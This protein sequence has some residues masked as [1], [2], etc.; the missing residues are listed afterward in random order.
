MISTVISG[1][2]FKNSFTYIQR[3]FTF[4]L[5][6]IPHIPLFSSNSFLK[7]KYIPDD[8]YLLYFNV[9]NKEM[10][11]LLKTFALILCG[12]ALAAKAVKSLVFISKKLNM[13]ENKHAKILTRDV[14]LKWVKL[15]VY[16]FDDSLQYLFKSQLLIHFVNK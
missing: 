11:C 4:S 7:S 6:F 1:D 16:V 14:L 15:G 2:F 13:N 9:S 10:K 8:V 3:A 12:V 5:S